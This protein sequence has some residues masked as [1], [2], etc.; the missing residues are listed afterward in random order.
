MHRN[1]IPLTCAALFA[2]AGCASNKPAAVRQTFLLDVVAPAPG[3]AAPLPGI[4]LVSSFD[5]ATAFAGK[6]MVYRFD[7]HR[8]Q[9]DFYNEFLVAPRELVGQ[10]ALEWLQGARLYETVAPL[11]G[12]RAPEALVLRGL[13]NEMYA[14]VRDPARPAAVLSIQFYIS[15]EQA[16]G[17]PVRFAQ[18]LRT[19]APMA[20]ASAAAY[21]GSLSHALAAILAELEQRLRAT[22]P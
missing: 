10:R 4:L 5:V 20:D 3:T 15:S 9:S 11:A 18:Q 16:D 17:R 6:Q 1:L 19:V 22:P 7:E 13:V 21:A 8:Y 12:S 2:L 14:D